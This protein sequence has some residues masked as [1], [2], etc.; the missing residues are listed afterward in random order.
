MQMRQAYRAP[1]SFF[2]YITSLSYPA[3][4]LVW[5]EILIVFAGI[6][7]A[8]GYINPAYGIAG[9]PAMKPLEQA[10]NALYFSVA[11]ATTVGYGDLAPLGWSRLF[12]GTEAVMGFLGLSI[13]IA[14]LVGHKQEMLLRQVHGLSFEHML[15]QTRE[16]LFLIRRDFDQI[17][18]EMGGKGSLSQKS[19]EN[20]AIA[21]SMC[22]TCLDDIPHFYQKDKSFYTLDS[23]R[24]GLLLDAVKRTLLQIENFLKTADGTGV[25]WR[26]QREVH[27][28]Y[29]SLLATLKRVVPIWQAFAA[30]SHK[31]AFAEI[32]KQTR[33]LQGFSTVK[34]KA[35]VKKKR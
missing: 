34:G 4:F 20:T 29:A 16:S 7:I 28:G 19:W 6:Y 18:S 5:V 22:E 3:L 31:E 11:T 27:E 35:V 8:L 10:W 33:G 32:M 9:L 26:K 2:G 30:P 13:F 24:E 25:D 17:L 21:L 15:H 14:K 12:A 23:K 1:L